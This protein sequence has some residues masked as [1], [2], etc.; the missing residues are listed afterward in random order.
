MQTFIYSSR[1]DPDT[2][3]LDAVVRTVIPVACIESFAG[4]VGFKKRLRMLVEPDSIAV[5]FIANRMEL[6]HMQRL[7]PLLTEIYIIMI[8]P[9]GEKATLAL[10]HLLLPRFLSRK[11]S[12]FVDLRIV[13]AKMYAH[14][15]GTPTSG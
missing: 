14:S 10:A 8:I 15:Q 11:E 3:R 13:L 12:D 1:D 4:L 6:E 5:L 2:K 9:D 7:C